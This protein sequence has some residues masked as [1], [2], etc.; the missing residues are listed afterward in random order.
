M[1]VFSLVIDANKLR[2]FPAS[3]PSPLFQEPI[4]TAQG[5]SC[6]LPE[7]TPTANTEWP[8][9]FLPLF[10]QSDHI[11]GHLRLQHGVHAFRLIW[12]SWSSCSTK[13]LDFKIE[14]RM[15]ARCKASD[16]CHQLIPDW[17]GSLHFLKV[18]NVSRAHQSRLSH[19]QY[20][21]STARL[22]SSLGH[23]DT[24]W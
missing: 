13:G 19:S 16:I 23:Y 20:Q 3:F 15:P 11:F 17:R 9:P 6:F 4:G 5:P 22:D 1:N 21:I 24:T 14:I 10:I 12:V 18:W 8:L 2:L 7:W